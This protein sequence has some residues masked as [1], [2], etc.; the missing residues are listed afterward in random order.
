MRDR[1]GIVSFSQVA[2]NLFVGVIAPLWIGLSPAAGQVRPELDQKIVPYQTSGSLSGSLSIS[3][4]ETMRPLTES[5]AADLRQLYPGLKISVTSEGSEAGLAKLLEGKAQIAAMSRR[6]NKEE[7]AEFIREFGYEPTEVPVAVDAL[8]VFVHKDNAI[9]GLTLAEVDAIFSNERRRGLKYP[10]LIWGDLLLDGEWK[11][12]PIHLYGRNVQSGTTTFFREHVLNGAALKKTMTPAP[13]SASVVIELMKD[14][15]GIGFSGIGYQTSGVR[16]VPL[17]SVQGGRYVAPSFQSAMDGSYPLR[18]NLYLYV[19]KIPKT[20]ASPSLVE[21]VKFALSQQ[22]QQ[23]VIA[24]GYYP[25]ATAE[26][27]RLT[28]MWNAPVRAASAQES[29]KLRD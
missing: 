3:G 6:I 18:R 23:T 5:W 17:A 26:L 9:E 15:F 13:G 10:L 16:A 25:L 11:E 22:G 19:N 14:R 1:A 12:A 24:Q 7:I 29:P 8:A 27:N 20:V 2:L 21:Y 28:M 4:S